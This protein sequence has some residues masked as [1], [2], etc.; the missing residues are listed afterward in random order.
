MKKYTGQLNVL[1]ERKKNQS[2]TNARYEEEQEN[3]IEL[4]ENI[5]NEISEAQ[6]TYKSLK[7]KQKNSTLSFVIRRTTI[8]FRRSTR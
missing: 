6:D 4:L 8:C 7:S 5:S 2:E 1:E 3:L